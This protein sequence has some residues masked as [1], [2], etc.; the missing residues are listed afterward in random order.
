MLDPISCGLNS[1]LVTIVNFK[2]FYLKMIN[3]QFSNH[4]SPKLSFLLFTILLLFAFLA[5]SKGALLLLVV[6][7]KICISVPCIVYGSKL[8]FQFQ[9][10]FN[11][12]PHNHIAIFTFGNKKNFKKI[13]NN[14]YF[15]I[16][17]F[18]FVPLSKMILVR[19]K[20]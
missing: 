19:S 20:P 5:I 3:F 1:T 16:L 4:L 17:N 9:T 8:L 10:T 7:F 14:N 12:I 13:Y 6:Q 2:P 11:I 15:Y 18:D